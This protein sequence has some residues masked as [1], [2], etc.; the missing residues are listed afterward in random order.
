MH[1][2]ECP[3]GICHW[4]GHPLRFTDDATWHNRQRVRH[5]GDKAVEEPIPV[6]IHKGNKLSMYIPSYRNCDREFRQSM[7]W[8]GQN[9]LRWQAWKESSD[10]NTVRSETLPQFERFLK[11]NE[12]AV[13]C[14]DCGDL[15]ETGFVYVPKKRIGFTT[16]NRTVYKKWEA[17]HEIEIQDG[18]AHTLENL[19][20]RCACCHDAKTRREAARRIR[21]IDAAAL[22]A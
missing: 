12:Y 11:A 15:C 10:K 13:Y 17:D 21:G 14:I 19:K 18:G 20:P 7:C 16:R 4:C 9:A 22:M 5:K 2:D 1:R 8:S 3:D 6:L